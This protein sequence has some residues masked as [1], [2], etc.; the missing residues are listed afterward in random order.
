MLNLNRL[1]AIKKMYHMQEG[2][3]QIIDNNEII[4]A[5]LLRDVE[6]KTVDV[7]EL[8][9]TQVIDAYETFLKWQECK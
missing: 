7:K 1:E 4:Y 3:E 2:T 6:G 5:W 8:D 9:D